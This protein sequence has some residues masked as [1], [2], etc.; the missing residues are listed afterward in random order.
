VGLGENR[1]EPFPLN[2]GFGDTWL[3]PSV[4]EIK[5]QS[6]WIWRRR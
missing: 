3:M 2:F 4:N 5:Q 1:L 6:F